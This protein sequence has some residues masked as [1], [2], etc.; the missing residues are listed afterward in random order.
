MKKHAIETFERTIAS[1]NGL[2]NDEFENFYSR[3]CCDFKCL[4]ANYQIMPENLFYENCANASMLLGSILI[5]KFGGIL[6]NRD[7]D[8]ILLEIRLI[9][10]NGIKD[11]CL[12][13]QIRRSFGC[14]GLKGNGRA[15]EEIIIAL[16]ISQ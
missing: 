7:S 6:I 4:L 16:E 12:Y 1:I 13:D 11:I 2:S 9:T 10:R 3:F 14:E 5:K 8:N 15:I